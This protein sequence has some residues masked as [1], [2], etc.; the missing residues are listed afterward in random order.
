V[1]VVVQTGQGFHIH[2]LGEGRTM[3]RTPMI[4]LAAGLL[5]SA[6]ACPPTGTDEPGSVIR[7]GHIV[8][9]TGTVY[10]FDLEGGFY[11]IRGDDDV[12]YDPMNLSDE[13]K[14]DGLR[15]RF[16]ANLRNDMGSFH[17]VGPIVEI[18]EIAPR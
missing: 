2:T 17:M 9:G 8:S 5:L 15:V 4:A 3:R 11:A 6:A 7:D 13:F 1:R 18:I 16:K 12:T 10:W 14:Q